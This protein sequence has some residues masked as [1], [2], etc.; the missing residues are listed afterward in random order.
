MQAEDSY[1]AFLSEHP[2]FS[3]D[4][5]LRSEV[6]SILETSPSVDLE[7]AY[8]AAKGKQATVQAEVA[9]SQKAAQRAAKR[10]AA[11]RG[12]APTRKA[13]AGGAPSKDTVRK[14][15]NSDILALAQSLHRNG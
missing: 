8:W 10:E 12:T 1:K 9:R 6:Q 5:A 7:T 15:S 13:Q 4:T 2:D 11:M 3:G 14:M